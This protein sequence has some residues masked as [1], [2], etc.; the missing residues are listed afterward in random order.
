MEYDGGFHNLQYDPHG[1]FNSALAANGSVHWGATHATISRS[2][3]GQV[4]AA[5]NVSFPAVNWAFM[6]SVYGWPALQYQAWARGVLEV[7]G[8]Q[9]QTVAL[10]GDGLLE[11][12]V[13][14]EP[15]FGGDMYQYHRAPSLVKLTPGPHTLELRLTRDVR[16]L[17]GLNNAIAVMIHA[18]LREPE[19]I[20]LYQDSLLVP[21]LVNGRLGS[22]W[23]SI[24]VLNNEE[25]LMELKSVR[26]L[27]VGS[28]IHLAIGYPVFSAH[29]HSRH[30]LCIACPCKIRC[31]LLGTR[32]DRWVLQSLLRQIMNLISR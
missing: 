7:K 28:F 16:A 18:E 15:Y 25:D 24:N 27:K 2:S 29:T 10:F 5:L 32:S 20:T 13:D 22:R 1:T 11:F 4:Q 21:E 23:A 26:A 14:G 6:Q 17:G 3:P 30:R 19:S 12:L 8:S 9:P 31:R